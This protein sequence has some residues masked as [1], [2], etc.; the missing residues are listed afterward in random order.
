MIG[1]RRAVPFAAVA[2]SSASRA[3]I[4]AVADVYDAVTSERPYKPAQPARVG[5]A[6]IASGA[7]SAFDPAVVDAFLGVVSPYPVGSEVRL[8]G[9]AT[10][11]VVD[12][13]PPQLIVRVPAIGGYRELR[14]HS[15]ELLAA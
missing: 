3:R 5:V 11:V 8:R 14:V 7:G 1:T 4:A 12:V 10:A 6:V 13:A 15:T 2:A 9:G